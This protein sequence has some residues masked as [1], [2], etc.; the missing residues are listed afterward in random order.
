MIKPNTPSSDTNEL[1]EILKELESQ[2]L[3]VPH[4][5]TIKTVDGQRSAFKTNRRIAKQAIEKLI[6]TKE[7]EAVA[8]ARIEWERS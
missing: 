7:A 6:T 4:T 8:K 2:T 1:D 3:H 5:Q